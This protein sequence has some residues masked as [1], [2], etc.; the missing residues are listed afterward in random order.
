MTMML[1][2]LLV[3]GGLETKRLS[4]LSTLHCAHLQLGPEV[5]KE[6]TR[7]GWGGGE[8][9]SLLPACSCQP[10][11]THIDMHTYLVHKLISLPSDFLYLF[12]LL[13][14]FLSPSP[15]PS[16]FYC[17]LRK[18]LFLRVHFH[19]CSPFFP[20][21]FFPSLPSSSLM[22]FIL[23]QMAPPSTAIFL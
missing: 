20:I 18:A 19:L 6:V 17:F 16:P 12:F 9:R 23:P 4:V 2:L 15:S 8:P 11:L 10:L 1:N 5:G 22:T 14:T 3:L 21:L 7:T 13:V